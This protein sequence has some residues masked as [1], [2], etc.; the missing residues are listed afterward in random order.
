MIIALGAGMLGTLGMF[1]AA[2]QLTGCRACFSPV[3]GGPGSLLGLCGLGFV[4]V[5]AVWPRR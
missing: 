3:D 4:F 1:T 5:G 2:D